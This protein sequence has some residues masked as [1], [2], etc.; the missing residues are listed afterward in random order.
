MKKIIALLLALLL[1]LSAVSVLACGGLA[2]V[3]SCWAAT[4]SAPALAR[5]QYQ[6]PAA[7]QPWAEA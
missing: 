2:V 3:P 7:I 1:C 4:E 5:V 6:L